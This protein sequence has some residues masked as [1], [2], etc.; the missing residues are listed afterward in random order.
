VPVV[1]V[2]YRDR[3]EDRERGMEV[4]ADAYLTK[5]DFQEDGFLNLVHDLIGAALCV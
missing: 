1:I 3:P 4:R 5:G 2:S